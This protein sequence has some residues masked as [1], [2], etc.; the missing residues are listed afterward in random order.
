MHRD[1]YRDAIESAVF[2]MQGPA[3]R[4]QGVTSLSESWP[5]AWP[6]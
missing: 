1:D 4:G 3:T 2:E 6:T 5:I